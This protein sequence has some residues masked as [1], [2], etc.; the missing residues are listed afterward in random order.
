MKGEIIVG[1]NIDLGNTTHLEFGEMRRNKSGR[2]K[3]RLS[4]IEVKGVEWMLL[5]ISCADERYCRITAAK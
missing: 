4:V 1:K 5:T 3:Q 2:K